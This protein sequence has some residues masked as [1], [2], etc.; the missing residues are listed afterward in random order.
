M[1]R[2]LA[3]YLLDGGFASLTVTLPRLAL[4]R[5]LSEQYFLRSA[6]DSCVSNALPQKSHFS[7]S[8]LLFLLLLLRVSFGCWISCTDISVSSFCL[9]VVNG[10]LYTVA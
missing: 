3:A 1:K 8:L 6:V 10:C 2:S 5:Q 4:L 7:S 9:F